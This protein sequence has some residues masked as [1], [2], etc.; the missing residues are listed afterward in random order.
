MYRETEKHKPIIMS[1]D[2]CTG[3]KHQLYELL[4]RIEYILPL[5][6]RLQIIMI[7]IYRKIVPAKTI[8]IKYKHGFVF[9]GLCFDFHRFEQLHC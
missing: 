9:T 7:A 4:Q 6:H 3:H 1:T 2:M 5:F 8:M